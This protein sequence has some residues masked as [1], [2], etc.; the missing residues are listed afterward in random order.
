[1]KKSTVSIILGVLV[2]A[3]GVF[4]GGQ[5]LG[6]W[7]QYKVSFDGWWTMFIIVPCVI[8]IIN[9]GFNLFNTIGAG[10]GVLLLLAA[11]DVLH[12]D[13]GYK[14]MIPYVLVVF[15]LSIMFR[16]PIRFR[17]ESNNGIF[18][19]N[20]GENYFAVFGGNTPQ[21]DGIDFRGANAYAIFGGI[22]LKLQNAIIRRDCVINSYSVFGGTDIILPKN[23]K[24]LV[25][26]TPIFGGVDNRFVNN[27][28]ENAPTVLIR[29]VSIFG[30]TD[31]K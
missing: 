30:G 8:S 16:R 24:V 15:G 14:L 25:D 1:M 21:F 6:F 12:N 10:I 31:I 13:L 20:Q 11:Q 4:F 29:A 17:K 9:S 19:G 26:S 18:A 5:A 27:A 28:G 22:D 7:E 3:L 23:V 2:I